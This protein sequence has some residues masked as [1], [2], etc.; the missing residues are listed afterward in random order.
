MKPRKTNVWFYV[1][2]NFDP[3]AIPELDG[4]HDEARWFVHKIISLSAGKKHGGTKW[5]NISRQTM[6]TFVH[7]TQVSVVRQALLDHGVV[8]CNGVWKKGIHSMGYRLAD[9]Y[10][11]AVVRVEVTKR[12]VAAKVVRHRLRRLDEPVTAEQFTATERYLRDWLMKVRIDTDRAFQIID[13]TPEKRRKKR[14]KRNPMKLVKRKA[15]KLVAGYAK[16]LNRMTVE[17]ISH[18]EFDFNV[19]AFGHR[20]HTPIT[21]LLTG[22]RSC[23]SF[24]DDPD[25]LVSLDVANSQIVFFILLLREHRLDRLADLPGHFESELLRG[26]GNG[27]SGRDGEGPAGRNGPAEQDGPADGT[28]SSEGPADR[29]GGWDYL[30]EDERRF[31]DLTISGRLYDH[32]MDRHNRT[33]EPDQRITDRKTFKH[34]LFRDVFYCNPREG[35]VRTSPLTK[36][37]KAEF[38]N[39]WDFI[40][41]AKE[42]DWKNLSRQMQRRESTYM[43]GC[44]VQ[45]LMDHHADIPVLTVHDSIVTPRRHAATV[46]RIMMAEFDRLGVQPKVHVEGDTD[47]GQQVVAA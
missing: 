8:V 26:I 17:Q 9:Q 43:I 32:L 39:V 21:R 15:R 42:G 18:R 29:N 11:T 7:A 25:P 36:L 10:R 20:V 13:A 37:F 6:A 19:D 35:Y 23:L 34:C 46:R 30:R 38:P 16:A 28:A 41:G 31:E 12:T 5:H 40:C 1:P 45:R 22:A 47:D 44:V 4:L 27:G 24:A 33:A 14:S 2:M 3:A